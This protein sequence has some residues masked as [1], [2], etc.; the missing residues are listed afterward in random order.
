M[1]AKAHLKTFVGIVFLTTFYKVFYLSH[2]VFETSISKSPVPIK[3][4]DEILILLWNKAYD[5][6][7]FTSKD[8]R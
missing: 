1:Q 6:L 7:I 4:N 5:K 3:K 8:F 2:G